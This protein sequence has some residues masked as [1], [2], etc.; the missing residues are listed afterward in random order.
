MTPTTAEVLE[1]LDWML[2]NVGSD[3]DRWKES[4]RSDWKKYDAILRAYRDRLNLQ[5]QPN[6][7]K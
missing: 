4:D 7:E 3:G 5:P 2:D 6:K 1:A